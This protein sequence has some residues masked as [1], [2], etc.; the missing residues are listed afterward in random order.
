[1]QQN[2]ILKVK[3]IITLCTLS[4]YSFVALEFAFC[5]TFISFLSFVVV[6]AVKLL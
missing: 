4:P 3:L 2:L 6:N 5:F 1:M